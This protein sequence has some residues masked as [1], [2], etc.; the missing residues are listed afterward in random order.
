MKIFDELNE[1][2]E[3]EKEA[4]KDLEKLKEINKQ[5]AEEEERRRQ[6]NERREKTDSKVAKLKSIL[7]DTTEGIDEPRLYTITYNH[8]EGGGYGYG[9]RIGAGK[10]SCTIIMTEREKM[11][12]EFTGKLE[13][14]TNAGGLAYGCQCTGIVGVKEADREMTDEEKIKIDVARKKVEV[15]NKS[16][17]ANKE[18]IIDLYDEEFRD[19][20]VNTS[21]K[22]ALLSSLNIKNGKVIDMDINKEDI[23]TDASSKD[24]E[25]KIT[26]SSI[27]NAIAK[28]FSRER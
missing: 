21:L 5:K 8:S 24:S 1:I 22:Y 25:K 3:Q 17:E 15:I 16:E 26:L 11:I 2:D 13:H 27:K 12:A 20:P 28:F 18:C 7:E 10:S 4:L 6:E 9:A 19:I 23:N 14:C